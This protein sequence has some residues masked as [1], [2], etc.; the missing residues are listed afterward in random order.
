[1]NKI[2]TLDNFLGGKL[3]IYQLKKGFRAGHDSVLLASA[4]K[5]IEGDS[6]LELGFGT[7]VVSLC[8]AKRIPNIDIIGIENDKEMLKISKKNIE[9]NNFKKN[10]KVFAG[11][12]EG[13]IENYKFIKRQSFDQIYANPPYFIEENLLE[14]TYKN[15]KIAN[16][17]N[18]KTFDL[19][20][21]KALTFSKSGG[22]ITFI[23][24]IQNLPEMLFLFS[25]KLG[26]IK[27]SDGMVKDGLTD[28]YSK[29][30][31]GVCAEICAKDM[32]FSRQEQDDFAIESYNRSRKSWE[33]GRFKDEI[34][35]VEVPQRNF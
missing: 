30:H 14:P 13:K 25:K 33:E 29:V 31:M 26:D 9:L 19:W 22:T 16:I 10:I 35:T 11:D 17:G 20:L 23:N 34:V 18:K 8:L 6:C 3:K 2:E 27:I 24:H 1:M 28:V 21:K 7:G 12:I 5:A 15:K 4:I 32:K